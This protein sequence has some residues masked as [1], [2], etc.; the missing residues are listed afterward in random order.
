MHP[1]VIL[2]ALSCG[3]RQPPVV[4][5]PTADPVK[6]T[7]VDTQQVRTTPLHKTFDSRSAALLTS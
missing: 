3:A 7:V 2:T 5:Q 1:L 6:L 4:A